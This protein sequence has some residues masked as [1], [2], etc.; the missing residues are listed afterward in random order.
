MTK[1]DRVTF[2][3]AKSADGPK[4]LYPD[5]AP[6]ASGR[7]DVGDGHTLYWEECGDPRGA[8]V[9][10][11][12]GGPGAGCSPTMRRF[13]HPKRWRVI[14]FDQRGAGR[15]TPHGALE[16]NSTW[17]L[18]ADIE[19]V[20]IHRKINQWTLFGGSWG[21]TL[22]L[23]YCAR[24]ASK[25][26]AMVLRGV[27]LMSPEEIA[28]FYGGGAGALLPEAWDRFLDHLPADEHDTPINAYYARLTSPDAATR[29]AAARAW[30]RWESVALRTP[31]ALRAPVRGGWRRRRGDADR[32]DDEAGEERSRRG[33]EALARIECHYCVN[34]G[35][36]EGPDALLEAARQLHDV[37]GYIVQGRFDLVTPPRAAWRLAQAWPEAQILIASGAGH[38]ASE[39][40]IVDGLVRAT[41]ALSESAAPR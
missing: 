5:I 23:A 30:T 40:Q 35:F 12:H 38:A 32:L 39:P 4:T 8:P 2:H 9:V 10:V 7:L 31:L 16:H 36:L 26:T 29:V 41:D 22:A 33:M 13:F 15:S 28:W 11:L 6:Y 27:F 37:P 21:S 34:Q 17:D 3:T 24:H 20:R 18:V 25:V 19:R 14:L 1:T